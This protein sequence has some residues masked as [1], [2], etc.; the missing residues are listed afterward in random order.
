MDLDLCHFLLQILSLFYCHKLFP[1]NE[2]KNSFFTPFMI[3][4]N[5]KSVSLQ[6]LQCVS[7]KK[8]KKGQRKKKEL[9]IITY[10]IPLSLIRY[11]WIINSLYHIYSEFLGR[12]GFEP[13][14]TYS[15][16]IYSPS[17]LTTRAST[18]EE[19]ILGLL[20]IDNS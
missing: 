4:K 12:A 1:F 5:H 7:V 18:Q 15:Q 8:K 10:I 19:S 14:Q 20:I 2:K 3:L 9:F 6:R 17:P 16:R 13:A 11:L